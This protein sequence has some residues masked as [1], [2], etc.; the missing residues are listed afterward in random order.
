MHRFARLLVLVLVAAQLLLAVPGMSWA[1]SGDTTAAE[2]HCDDMP[3]PGGDDPMPCCPD[4]IASSDCLASCLLAA[5][6]APTV[7]ILPTPAP[8]PAPVAEAPADF[9]T[10]FEPPLK[11]PPIA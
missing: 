1:Q 9:E 6:A 4:G 5:A 11:P 2:S 8:T 3:A 10:L 7:S